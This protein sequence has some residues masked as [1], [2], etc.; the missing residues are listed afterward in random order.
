MGLSKTCAMLLGSVLATAS[1]ALAAANVAATTGGS[2]GG[3]AVTSADCG[4]S[5]VPGVTVGCTKTGPSDAQIIVRARA[6]ADARLRGRTFAKHDGATND[7]LATASASSTETVSFSELTVPVRA[8]IRLRLTGTQSTSTDA[9]GEL[10]ASTQSFIRLGVRRNGSLAASDFDEIVLVRSQLD[11]GTFE[12]NSVGTQR[13]MRGVES[14]SSVDVAP[15]LS[16]FAP[17][18]EFWLDPGTSSFDWF[19]QFATNSRIESGLSG[20][21]RTQYFNTAAILGLE[22]LDADGMDVSDRLG[23]TF[24]SGASYPLGTPA[25]PEPSSWA[26]MIAGFGLA[27]FALRRRAALQMAG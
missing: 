24:A 15:D 5:F 26:L 13:T 9:V 3:A 23:V 1:P 10:G 14:F 7:T 12:T 16:R 27:G 17:V 19:W 6:E 18:L 20:T 22:F 4:Q 11:Y 21:A 25:I 8:R 2:V